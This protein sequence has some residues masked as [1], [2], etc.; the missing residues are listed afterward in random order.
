MLNKIL[1]LALICFFIAGA[2]QASAVDSETLTSKEFSYQIGAIPAFVKQSSQSVPATTKG[3]SGGDVALLLYER[4]VS[5]LDHDPQEYVHTQLRPLTAAALKDVSQVNIIFNPEYQKL[6]LHAIRIWRDGKAIDLT[7]EVKLDLLRRENDLEN[8][9]YEGEVTAVGILPDTRVN[10]VIEAEYTVIGANPIFAGHFSDEYSMTRLQL[11]R[12][13]HFSLVTPTSRPIRVQPPQGVTV[14]ETQENG[15]TIYSVE[16]DN[17]APFREEDRT[18]AWYPR[19]QLIQVSEYKDWQEVGDWAKGLFKVDGTLSPEIQQQIQTWKNSGLPKD[20][21]A[22]EVLRWVQSQIRY[23]GIELGVNSHLPAPPNLTVQRKFGDCKDKSLL[24]TTMLKALDIDAAPTLASLSYNRGTENMIPSAA[25]FDHAIVRANIDGKTYWLDPTRS[26]QYGKLDKL[27][28]YEYGGVLVLDDNAK[29]LTA[30]RYT[31]KFAN[32][33]LRTDHF[34]FD[35][36]KNGQVQ[37]TVRIKTDYALAE[38]FRNLHDHQSREEFNKSFQGGDFLRFYPK[39]TPVGD[40]ELV[41][42][43]VNNEATITYRY[44]IDDFF[45][46]QPGYLI[47]TFIPLDVM[48]MAEFPQTTQR[49]SPFVLADHSVVTE[50]MEFAFPETSWIKPNKFNDSKN[51][52]FWNFSVKTDTLPKQAIMT[53]SISANKEA[54]PAQKIGDYVSEARGLRNQ[55]SFVFRLPI[56]KLSDSDRKKTILAS[57][58]LTIKYGKSASTRVALEVKNANEFQTLSNDIASGKLAGKYLATA[59]KERGLI[60]DARDDGPHAMADMRKANT[61]D[62]DNFDSTLNEAEMFWLNRQFA[63]ALPLFEHVVHMENARD[64]GLSEA[65]WKYAASLHYLGQHD[66]AKQ[67]AEEAVNHDGNDMY[68]L[69]WRYIVS[70]ATPDSAAELQSAMG[71]VQDHAWPYEVGDLLLGKVTPEQ[72]IADANSDDTG[73]R[74]DH[75][76]EAYFY[77]G[78]KYLMTGDKA[79][80]NESFQKSVDQGVV[81]YTEHD[82]SLYELGKKRTP[83]AQDL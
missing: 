51:G 49:E 58:R 48:G 44:T 32:H 31:A 82:F 78:E 76:C 64:N 67:M 6:T 52:E 29:Q 25:V 59:Y 39:A 40:V 79:K 26:P 80:A 73:L 75:Y 70:G 57:E 27:G 69:L 77:I 81:P 46:Y 56:S 16:K 7:H 71:N 5:L 3:S 19:L 50:A 54:V 37:L 13:Y 83:V 60:Y 1:R 72:L 33:Y 53:W 41:D 42:D 21:L 12:H 17:V 8:G 45:Q 65:Y 24:L 55:M 22:V 23:F 74:E 68:A 61:L 28:A 66:K 20:Q 2:G 43:K 36:S 38:N 63:E 11:A 9:M 47:G 15:T 14:K 34:D 10:D 62:P 35:P 4:Q 18:P 30:S